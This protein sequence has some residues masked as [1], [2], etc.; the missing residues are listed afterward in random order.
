M[1][2]DIFCGHDQNDA[3]W[4]DAVESLGAAADRMNQLA[5]DQPGPYFV[6]C[7][8]KYKVLASID[9]SA[10]SRECIHELHPAHDREG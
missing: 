9:T 1:L 8:N 7:T 3:I 5:R 4:I 6:F 2:Y 10:P